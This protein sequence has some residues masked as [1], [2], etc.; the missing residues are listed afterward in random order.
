MSVVE[1][2]IGPAANTYEGT[3]NI[4]GLLIFHNM[5]LLFNLCLP[6]KQ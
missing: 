3:H 6:E 2:I 4:T 5:V 1:V